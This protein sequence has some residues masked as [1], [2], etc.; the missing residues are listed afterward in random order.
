MGDDSLFVNKITAAVLSAGLLAMLSGFAAHMLYSPKEL[1]KPAYIIAEDEPRAVVAKAA[2]PAGP[3]PIAGML[4]AA[5][6]DAGQKVAKKCTACHSFTKGG[7]NK[8]GPNLWN[9]VGGKP[10]SVSGYKYSGA[11]SGMTVNW[12]YEELNKFL[13]KP[14]AYLKGTKMSFAGL[15][16]ARDRATIIAYLRSLSDNPKPLP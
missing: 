3:E 15:K 5:N 7:A 9:V 12:E 2:A 1:D 16:K 6:A 14:K 11:M 8:V 13:Y 4:A 10:A